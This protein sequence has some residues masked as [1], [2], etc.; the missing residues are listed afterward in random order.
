MY[1]F[2]FEM[3]AVKIQIQAST[4]L[5]FENLYK[6]NKRRKMVVM[7]LTAIYGITYS[8][9]RILVAVNN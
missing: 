4:L 6:V 3:Q 5:D 1:Y 2:V 7:I 9:I 8:T